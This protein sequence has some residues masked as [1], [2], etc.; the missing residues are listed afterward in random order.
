MLFA[1]IVSTKKELEQIQILNQQNLKQ[2]LSEDEM[3]QEGF[4]SWNYSL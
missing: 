3:L 2:N 1:T 4:V